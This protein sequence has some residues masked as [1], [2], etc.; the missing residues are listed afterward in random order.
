MIIK[1]VT[2]YLFHWLGGRGGGGGGIFRPRPFCPFPFFSLT[3]TPSDFLT[4]EPAPQIQLRYVGALL[5]FPSR[6]KDICSH[7]TRFSGSK[8]TK[9]GLRPQT[10][11]LVYLEPRERV[12][13]QQMSHFC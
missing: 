7:Q 2:R 6:E 11:F 4:L 3:L 12:W 9:N 8:Y 5:A 1:A 10:H 13:W